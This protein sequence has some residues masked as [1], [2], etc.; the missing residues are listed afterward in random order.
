MAALFDCPGKGGAVLKEN[1]HGAIPT[2][3]A[4]R[5]AEQ[6]AREQALELVE[7]TLQKLPQGKTL[8]VY[9]DKP[10]GV[11]LDDCERF[12]KAIQPMLETV[13]YDFLEVSSPGVDRPVKTLRDFEKNQNALVEVK[14]FAPL[15]GA[16][17]YTGTLH[18]MPVAGQWQLRWAK[19]DKQAV[20][21]GTYRCR[22]QSGEKIGRASC[23]ERA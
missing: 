20:G 15:D 8:C 23:R 4:E 11:T 18:A 2:Q 22:V 6:V 13:D 9:I 19:D 1:R 5:I 7:V 3:A 10:G 14:L 12:H 21:P 17:T 16:K